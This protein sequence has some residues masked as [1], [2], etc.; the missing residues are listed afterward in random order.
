LTYAIRTHF[1]HRRQHCRLLPACNVAA[2]LNF[3]TRKTRF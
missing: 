3:P 2:A 1:I